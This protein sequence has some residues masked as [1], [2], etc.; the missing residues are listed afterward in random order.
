MNARERL[1]LIAAIVM[2]GAICF[3]FVIYDP[4]QAAYAQLVQAHDAASQQLARNE[5]IAARAAAVHK[6]YA[7]LAAFIAAVEAKL[8][9]TKEIPALLTAMERF[10]Q[11]MG[12][13]FS[14]IQ[15]GPLTPVPAGGTTAGGASGGAK[16]APKQGGAKAV[17]Y[18]RMEV[19][20][21]LNGTF[22][23]LVQYLHDLRDFPRLI[24][25]DSI[26]LSPQKLPKLAAGLT[27]EIFV[28]GGPG[29]ATGAAP[30]TPAPARAP[31][32]G[33]APVS[34]PPA[35][36]S[37]APSQIRPVPSRGPASP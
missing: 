37:G 25:V 33:A 1:M 13:G 35:S 15:P 34:A 29:A 6:E 5:Q 24:I 17:P 9:A 28:M 2:L 22:A 18:S 31:A 26:S 11:T 3:K 30:A 19:R 8:P 7:R 10:T 21:A 23:Q 20:L 16:P 32:G 14:S 4:Q 36:V 27:T 12:V